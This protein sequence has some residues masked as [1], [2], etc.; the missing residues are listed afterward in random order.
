VTAAQRLTFLAI[1]VVI[2]IAGVVLL[3]ALGAG[4]DQGAKVAATPTAPATPASGAGTRAPTATPRPRPPLIVQ[5]S[6]RTLRFTEG[7]TIRFRVRAEQDDEVHVH[8]YDKLK[9]VSAGRTVTFAFPASITGIFEVELENA[10][11]QL[12]NLRVDPR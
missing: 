11:L 8:G 1:G 3:L 6:P 5:G 9:R 4:G 2:A 7:D 12:G 10:G